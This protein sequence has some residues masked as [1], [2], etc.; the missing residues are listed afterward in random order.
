MRNAIVLAVVG[1]FMASGAALAGEGCGFGAVHSA[2]SGTSTQTV[3]SGEP[4]TTTPATKE[5][6]G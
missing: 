3:V 1:L 6:K 2:S 4:A 5:P